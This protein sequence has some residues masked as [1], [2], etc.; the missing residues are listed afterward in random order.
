MINWKIREER[1]RYFSAPQMKP[2]I[3]SINFLV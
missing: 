1:I 2:D 3:K